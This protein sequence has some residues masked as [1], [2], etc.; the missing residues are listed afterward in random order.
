MKS[1]YLR[2]CVAL[3]CAAGLAACGGSGGNLVLGGQVVGLNRDGLVLTNKG[4]D[5]PIPK[6]STQFS[7]PDLIAANTEFDITVKTDPAGMKC[8]PVNAKG[9]TSTFAVSGIGIICAAFPRRL[10]G[11]I[12]GQSGK[13]VLANGSDTLE[14]AAEAKFFEFHQT[15]GDGLPYGVSVLSAPAGQTCSVSNGSA[16]IGSSNLVGDTP[17]PADNE[18]ASPVAVSCVTTPH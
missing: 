9:T 16:R 10:G 3:V 17:K 12:S 15:V 13:L 18:I 1:L 5:L 8:T 2:S 6:G 4:V 7:F 14:V 11:T